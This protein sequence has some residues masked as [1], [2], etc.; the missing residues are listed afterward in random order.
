MMS[1]SVDLRDVNAALARLGSRATDGRRPLGRFYATFKAECLLAL[2]KVRTP[3]G[4]Y[5]GEEFPRLADQYTRKTDGVTVPAEGGVARLRRGFRKATVWASDITTRKTQRR[6]VSTGE[7]MARVSG[8]V[9]GRLRGSGKR[10]AKNSP[11]M[12]DTGELL[13]RLFPQ[14]AD[15]TRERLRLGADAPAHYR[16]LAKRRPILFF[17]PKDQVALN[18]EAQ[19]YLGELAADFNRGGT[20]A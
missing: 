18:E 8:N 19:R 20:R 3:G 2:Q 5:R 15:I 11:Q 14:R 10:I 16:H 4:N 9:S 17:T 1:I 6:G 12:N 7:R 13:R